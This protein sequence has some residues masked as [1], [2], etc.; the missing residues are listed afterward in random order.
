MVGSTMLFTA[1]SI[2][3]LILTPIWKYDEKF[4]TFKLENQ[5]ILEFAGINR[6]SDW[7]ISIGRFSRV[8]KFVQGFD[9]G[10][11]NYV[12]DLNNGP[13]DV[14]YFTGSYYLGYAFSDI[15]W[16]LAGAWF[17]REGVNF[18]SERDGM[19]FNSVGAG[20]IL[21]KKIDSDID[22]GV[23]LYANCYPEE[24]SMFQNMQIGIGIQLEYRFGDDKIGYTIYP[25]KYLAHASAL[26]VP[27]VWGVSTGKATGT[28]KDIFETDLGAPNAP[29]VGDKEFPDGIR[30]SSI[31]QNQGPSDSDDG[32]APD[33]TARPKRPTPAK[34]SG[35]EPVAKLTQ[36]RLDEVQKL[37]GEAKWEEALA[38]TE[39]ELTVHPGHANLLFFQGLAQFKLEKFDEA[40]ASFLQVQKTG[41]VSLE[42]TIS[43]SETL[44]YLK[45]LDECEKVLRE[46]M[47]KFPKAAALWYNLG[48]IHAEKK[49]PENAKKMYAEAL[50]RDKEFGP[51]LY[52]MADLYASEKAFDKA[53]EL[54]D[55]LTQQD[56]YKEIAHT[57]LAIVLSYQKKWDEA[58]AHVAQLEKLNVGS[59][60]VLRDKILGARAFS[61]LGELIKAKKCKEAKAHF[62][63][64]KKDFPTS[65]ALSKAQDLLSR[66]CPR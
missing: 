10:V 9:V 50:L 57:K 26:I 63:I 15:S 11:G 56:K 23:K 39:K 5:G 45:K 13:I 64:I 44:F 34:D 28:L 37:I 46:G 47:L 49:D 33:D 3:N 6:K 24:N 43:L 53:T 21:R 36:P 32:K 60:K 18:D 19:K 66:K 25:F 7:S 42:L 35:T 16:L 65:A 38:A 22:I 58:L 54:L 51:A 1:L 52:S 41:V 20:F 31:A 61:E 30:T 59:S 62:E 40:L 2:P 17:K 55:K 14:F 4:W 12:G 48:G 27:E 8:E 29:S